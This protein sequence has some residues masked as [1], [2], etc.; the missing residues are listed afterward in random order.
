MQVDNDDQWNAALERAIERHGDE[1]LRRRCDPST[2]G[3]CKWCT[4]IERAHVRHYLGSESRP[5]PGLSYST[6]EHW[7]DV[8]E[9]LRLMGFP[10]AKRCESCEKLWAYSR[11][12]CRGGACSPRPAA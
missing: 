3:R 11:C 8:V 12:G 5:A 6:T 4:A 9:E 2:A 7:P 10:D 1:D